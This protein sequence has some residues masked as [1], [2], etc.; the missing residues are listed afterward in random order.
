MD[1]KGELYK[2]FWMIK[3]NT[4]KQKKREWNRDLREKGKQA[5]MQGAMGIIIPKGGLDVLKQIHLEDQ[6]TQ[7]IRH[8]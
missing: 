2:S 5:A 1:N 8:Q 3:Q 7:E 6:Q 4:R